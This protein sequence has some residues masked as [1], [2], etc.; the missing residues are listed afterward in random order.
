M[1]NYRDTTIIE[2]MYTHQTMTVDEPFQ[3]QF[4][5]CFPMIDT[6]ICWTYYWSH[7]P[8]DYLTCDSFMLEYNPGN[9]S[10]IKTMYPL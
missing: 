10:W 8:Q 6:N 9:I 5:V 1:L 7:F 3:E 2:K 4:C